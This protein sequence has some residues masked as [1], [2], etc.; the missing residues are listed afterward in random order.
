M[1][2]VGWDV[3]KSDRKDFLF[4]LLADQNNDLLE[5]VMSMK[6]AIKD[7]LGQMLEDFEESMKELQ[8][9]TRKKK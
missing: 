7:I 3:I 5:E 2:G 8:N 6:K 4:H 1:K 9:E